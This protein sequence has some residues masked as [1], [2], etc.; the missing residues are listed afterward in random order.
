MPSFIS[1]DAIATKNLPVVDASHPDFGGDFSGTADIITALQAAINSTGGRGVV[2]IPGSGVIT[3]TLTL[4]NYSPATNPGL[5]PIM[6]MGTERHKTM[7]INMA[8]PDTP[9]LK[10]DGQSLV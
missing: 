5:S 1:I 2:V 6:L 10:I 9:T 4:P 7:L 8:P 3:S